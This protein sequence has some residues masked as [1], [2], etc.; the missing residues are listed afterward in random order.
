M[1]RFC[2][3][4]AALALCLSAPAPAADLS[5]EKDRLLA[6]MVSA[7]DE[8]IPADRAKP[9]LDAVQTAINERLGP[10][11]RAALDAALKASKAEADPGREAVRTFQVA[12]REVSF[13]DDQLR[14]LITALRDS[15]QKARVAPTPPPM[16]YET[17]SVPE[18]KGP[19]IAVLQQPMP[20]APP[21]KPADQ[22]FGTGTSKKPGSDERHQV[23]YSRYYKRGFNGADGWGW[24]TSSAGYGGGG[25]GGGHVVVR[26]RAWPRR[27]VNGVW[28]TNAK[29]SNP[30]SAQAIGRSPAFRASMSRTNRAGWARATRSA[31]HLNRARAPRAGGRR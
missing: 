12:L 19:G 18:K 1:T 9:F 6:D 10:E 13:Q 8:G 4:I 29:W 22:V 24:G 25:G 16:S 30:G 15:L 3:V 23:D 20:Q 7:A 17:P 27:N 5:A 26:G 31:V 28:H 14:G 2:T 21:P 11:Q